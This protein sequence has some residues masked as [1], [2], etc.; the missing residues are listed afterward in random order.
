MTD[1]LQKQAE[2]LR[3][4]VQRVNMLADQLIRDHNVALDYE[5]IPM[6]VMGDRHPHLLLRESITKEA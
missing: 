1:D 3:N 6:T 4:A 5:T 2:A